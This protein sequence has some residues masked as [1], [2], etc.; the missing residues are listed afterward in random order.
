MPDECD[1][2][3]LCDGSRKVTT[4]LDCCNGLGLTGL[5]HHVC[6]YVFTF[7]A[8]VPALIAI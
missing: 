3:L 4:G 2:L 7:K 1:G 8:V 5:M 6:G